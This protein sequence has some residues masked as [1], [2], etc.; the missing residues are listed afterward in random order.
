MFL[1]S[2]SFA[3]TYNPSPM[4]IAKPFDIDQ[5]VLSKILTGW[6]IYVFCL[7]S[8]GI[9]MLLATLVIGP[10]LLLGDSSKREGRSRAVIQ[11]IFQISV[12]LYRRTGLLKGDL[13]ELEQLPA[14]GP[15]VL[16]ANHPCLLDA[17]FL[18]SSL[19]NAVCIMKSQVSR[20]PFLGIGATLAGYISNSSSHGL[21]RNA[22]AC[23]QAGGQL[24][25]F[26]EGTRTR[27]QP[28]SNMKGAFATIAKRA[29]VPVQLVVIEC[30]SRFLGK[31]WPLWRIPSFP[32]TFKFRVVETLDPDMEREQMLA[33]VK[34]IYQRELPVSAAAQQAEAVQQ[35]RME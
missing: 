11:R 26:P 9:I 21:V 10:V 29:G 2:C 23:L 3:T 19:P 34:E 14:R 31:D 28:M 16:V 5:P 22:V 35:T 18:V 15:M 24:V 30:D 6:V 25:V 1:S 4:R 8:V 17:L 7:A 27:G 33:T 32:I 12:S 13:T 20:N